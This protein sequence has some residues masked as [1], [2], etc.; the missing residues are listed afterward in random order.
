M[1]CVPPRFGDESGYDRNEHPAHEARAMAQRQPG[2]YLRTR[3]IQHCH[4]QCDVITVD[5]DVGDRFK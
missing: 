2:T 1:D 3:D 4:A 5:K